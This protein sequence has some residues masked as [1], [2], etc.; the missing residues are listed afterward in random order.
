VGL[1]GQKMCPT[2]TFGFANIEIALANL[3]YH[4]H[5]KTPHGGNPCELDMTKAYG[6]YDTKK[7]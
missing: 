4:F 3:L 2:L 1:G 6:H 5:W 7:D